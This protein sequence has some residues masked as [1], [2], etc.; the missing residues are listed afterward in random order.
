MSDQ[1]CQDDSASWSSPA[2]L[3]DGGFIP[4]LL[5]IAGMF[6]GISFVCEEYG[7]PS[8]TAF[9]K[10]NKLSDALTGSIF[11]GTGL[12]LPV[13]FVA[14]T[15][16]FA[17][18]SAIGVGAVVGGNLFNHLFTIASSIYVCPEKR[19]KLDAAVFTR[20][21]LFYFLSCVLVLWAV[22]KG[23]LRHAFRNSMKREQWNS[24]LTIEW[25]YSLIL[26]VAYVAYC[27][28]DANFFLVENLTKRYCHGFSYNNIRYES[29]GLSSRN[30]VSSPSSSSN[31]VTSP[32]TDCCTTFPDEELV[33]DPELATGSGE[34]QTQTNSADSPK[35]E[36]TSSEELALS[37]AKEQIVELKVKSMYVIMCPN[38]IKCML[39]LTF[40]CFS[41]WILPSIKGIIICTY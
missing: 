27:I 40:F 21:M 41:G 15:G 19:M 37:L 12:S 30:L 26:V 38:L 34:Q 33:V 31:E 35:A 13:F 24:C 20:E 7:I 29:S 18:N 10:R 17:S 3:V 8:L 4:V 6:W 9:C 32:S 22:A 2:W 36:N 28:I 39:I 14:V 25:K 11:I 5:G 1:S 23:S 16:L